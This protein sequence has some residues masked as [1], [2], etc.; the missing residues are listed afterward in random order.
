M[1]MRSSP[2]TKPSGLQAWRMLELPSSEWREFSVEAN[3][4][5]AG[6]CHA[7]VDQEQRHGAPRCRAADG[8]G[9]SHRPRPPSSRP[10]RSFGSPAIYWSRAALKAN[11][12]LISPGGGHSEYRASRRARCARPEAHFGS[13]DRVCDRAFR[14]Q[15]P[16]R[17]G[18]STSAQAP[19]RSSL[20]H[21][22]SGTTRRALALTSH[23]RLCPMHRP[24]QGGLVSRPAPSWCRETGRRGCSRS[25]T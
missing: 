11:R 2:R 21:W 4:P 6:R 19:E 23:A 13:P 3:C 14:R 8:R 16:D 15:R 1:S 20:L 24:M 9:A 10:A 18:F 17:D 5:R 25:S 7:P 22:T 12:S